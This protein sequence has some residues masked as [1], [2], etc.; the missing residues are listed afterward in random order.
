MMATGNRSG[1]A[2]AVLVAAGKGE[3]FGH[4][5]K[6]LAESCGRP[7][8][9]WS[10]DALEAAA[11][12][13]DVVIVYAAHTEI[14]LRALVANEPW[15]KVTALVEGGSNRQESVSCG[16]AAVADDLEIVLIHDAARP[17]VAT[18]QCDACAERARK[19]G[20]AILAIPVADTLKRVANG[21][22]TET[23]PRTGMWAAQTP[24]AFRLAA[25]RDAVASIHGREHES[26][27]D[28]SIF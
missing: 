14:E 19:D 17:M 2:A 3:R 9:A 25:Y 1:Y 6:V 16:V 20:A 28:A 15:T 18:A 21:I 4:A 5:G 27:D 7:L 12:V 26:T 11:S 8:V 13:R 23:V 22:I 10:L 24:Q